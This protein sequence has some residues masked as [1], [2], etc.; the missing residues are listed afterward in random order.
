MGNWKD[1]RFAIRFG[2]RA[3]SELVLPSAESFAKGREIAARLEAREKPVK[4][5]VTRKVHTRPV[6]DDFL[7]RL[8]SDMFTDEV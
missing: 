3:P 6:S 7:A 8:L 1:D 2:G 5:Q 4:I